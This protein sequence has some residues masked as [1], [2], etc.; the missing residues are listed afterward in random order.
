MIWIL[1]EPRWAPGRQRGTDPLNGRRCFDTQSVQYLASSKEALP[2]SQAWA[3]ASTFKRLGG[4]DP[5][6]VRFSY[7]DTNNA[8][9]SSL[10]L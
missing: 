9:K 2:L 8:W 10:A 5:R 6:Q 3:D 1:T 4:A 7:L